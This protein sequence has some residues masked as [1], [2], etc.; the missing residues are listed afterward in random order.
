M[1][2]EVFE[3]DPEDEYYDQMCSAAYAAMFNSGRSKY[4]VSIQE[5]NQP[6]VS[7]VSNC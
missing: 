6:V 2:Y 5:R 3:P 4:S 1:E 7:N